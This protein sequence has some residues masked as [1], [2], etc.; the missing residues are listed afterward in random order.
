MAARSA[1]Q[2]SSRARFT[3]VGGSVVL[4]GLLQ[5]FQGQLAAFNLEAGVLIAATAILL[6]AAMLIQQLGQRTG[7]R[8]ALGERNAELLGALTRWP[9]EQASE[10]SGYELGVR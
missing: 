3:W 4:L 10:L 7:A 1:R 2:T 8:Q 9:L 6:V 5:A